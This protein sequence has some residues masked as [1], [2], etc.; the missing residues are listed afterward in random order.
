MRLSAVITKQREFLTSIKNKRETASQR[1]Q[2]KGPKTAFQRLS[3]IAKHLFMRYC[4]KQKMSCASMVSP[5][6]TAQPRPF[7][8]TKI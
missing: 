8:R 6:L 2:P 4:L 5:A 3:A 1:Q 7:E